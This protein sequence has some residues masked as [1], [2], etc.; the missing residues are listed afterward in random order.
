MTW[1][2]RSNDKWSWKGP[3]HWH[4]VMT[5][6]IR[7]HELHQTVPWFNRKNG[8][9]LS[10]TGGSRSIN[11]GCIPYH[12][13]SFFSLVLSV[14]MKCQSFYS[15]PKCYVS[16]LNV[17]NV[18]FSYTC[19]RFHFDKARVWA[20]SLFCSTVNCCLQRKNERWLRKPHNCLCTLFWNSTDALKVL[21]DTSRALPWWAHVYSSSRAK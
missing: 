4:W 9:L 13:W 14:S 6:N 15:Q 18:I 12:L 5:R 11:R 21:H 19:I 8:F 20:Q 1:P 17:K 7:K 10:R 3:W 2:R 16:C